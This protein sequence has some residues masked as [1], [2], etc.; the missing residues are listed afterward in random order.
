MRHSRIAALLCVVFLSN[1]FAAQAQSRAQ[2]FVIDPSKPYVYLIF[3]HIGKREPISKHEPAT[4]IWLRLVN[5]CRV[6]V[7]IATFDPGTGDPS[8]GVYD[9]IISVPANGPS[10]RSPSK[11]VESSEERPWEGYSPSEVLSTTTIPPRGAVLFSVPSNHVSRSWYLQIKFYLGVPS[12]AYGKGPYSV[13]PF[14]WQDLPEKL[15]TDQRP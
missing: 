11:A 9:E 1:A 15:R 10:V 6:P 12:A 4:G 14:Y 13:V 7:I 3:D 2:T 8:L 5:N